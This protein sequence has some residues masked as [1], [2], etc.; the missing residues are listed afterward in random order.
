MPTPENPK[1]PDKLSDEVLRELFESEHRPDHDERWAALEAS[2]ASAARRALQ[3]AEAIRLEE[4]DPG[5][6]YLRGFAD[7]NFNR[8]RQALIEDVSQSLDALPEVPEVDPPA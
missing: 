8:N 5:D 1:N 6:A 3:R 2:D 7:A 4:V